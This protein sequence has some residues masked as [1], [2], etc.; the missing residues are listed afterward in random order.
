MDNDDAGGLRGLRLKW[1]KT[2]DKVGV[3]MSNASFQSDAD[4]FVSSVAAGDIDNALDLNHPVGDHDFLDGAGFGFEPSHFSSDKQSEYE[5]SV[6]ASCH[7]TGVPLDVGGRSSFSD[8]NAA[9]SD[10]FIRGAKF[11]A[12]TMPW[13][14]PLMRQIFGD[15]YPGARLSMPIDWGSTDLPVSEAAGAGVAAP[16]IPCERHW[17]CSQYV[18]HKTDETFIQQREKTMHGALAKWRFLVCLHPDSSD[19]GRQITDLDEKQVDE[20]L[21]SVMGVKSPNTVL[22]RANALMTYYRWHAVN[23]DGAMVPFSESDVWRYVMGQ[24][25][26]TSSASRSQSFLQ[27]LRFAHFVMGFDNALACANSRR[28]SGQAQIQ[29]STKDPVRQARPLTVAEV[30]TLHGIACDESFSKVDR[31]VASNLLLL[32][33]GRCRVSDVNFIHEILH[34]LT[35][36]TGFLEVTTRYHKSAKSAQ[37]KAMLLPIVISSV[38]VVQFP[39]M[40]AWISNRKTCGLPTSGLVQGALLPA[41][42][43]GDRVEWMKRPLSPGEVTNILKGFLNCSDKNLS[44]HSLKATALSWAAKA[45][46]PRDQRRILGR[47]T[48]AIQGSDSFYSRDMSIG[49]VNALQKVITLIRDGIFNPDAT[50]ANYFAGSSHQ[51]VGTPAHIVMQPFTPAFGGRVQPGTPGLD[52][53]PLA[54]G[55]ATGAA[56]AHGALGLASDVKTESSWSLVAGDV[57]GKVIDISSDSGV[58]SSESDT[59]SNT[60]GQGDSTDVELEEEAG[61]LLSGDPSSSAVHV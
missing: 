24:T 4:V 40:H 32:L 6:A 46:I 3:D 53:V 50:R 55:G 57:A 1:R 56:V 59:C 38:G 25:G 31:C 2:S 15:E 39:W 52:E 35:G 54:T 19:V 45:E 48:D 12:V 26:S 8:D 17:K 5:P 49:P 30:K 47:H 58:D 51:S 14:T 9:I 7:D 60:S 11:S 36:G 44:S 42:S 21:I 22:K 43:L 61:P 33:Y 16:V 18:Q 23:C 34:D 41:P 20:V 10:M 37:Q 28:V 29:L 13:E 27:S